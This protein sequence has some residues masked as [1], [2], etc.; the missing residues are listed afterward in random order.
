MTANIY[1]KNR[2]LVSTLV[3]GLALAA[4]AA[5][6]VWPALR[7]ISLIRAQVYDERVRLEKL[8]VRG[9]LQKKVRDNFNRIKDDTKFLDEIWLREREELPYITALEQA[10]A[11]QAV[12]LKIDIGEAKRVPQQ[13]FSTL[14]FNFEITGEWT[15]LLGWLDAVEA[16]PYYTNLKEIAVAVHDGDKSE[17]AKARVATV[18]ISADTYWLLPQP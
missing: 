15:A 4:V 11:E 8:Y 17:P 3:F 12:A 7:E 13:L 2:F 14:V 9:Q 5:L 18:N 6:V 16:M 1:L 10:A